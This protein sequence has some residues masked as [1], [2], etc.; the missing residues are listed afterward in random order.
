VTT[1]A[2]LLSDQVFQLN[3][4]LWA[5]ED[6]PDEGAIDPVLRSAG[7]FLSSIGRRVI[8]PVDPKTVNALGELTG[9]VDRSPCHPDLW[10]THESDTVDPIIELKARGFSP[11][12]SN[13]R[14]ALKLIA[15]AANLSPSKRGLRHLFWKHILPYGEVK[16]NITQRLALTEPASPTPR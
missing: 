15:S 14:Q 6:L 13:R 2:A 10:L 11:E 7:Y 16:L 3:T 9:S 8:A 5:L 12:S 1:E 4:F